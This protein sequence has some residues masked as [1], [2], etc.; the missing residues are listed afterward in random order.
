MRAYSLSSNLMHLISF[1]CLIGVGRAS[2][3]ILNIIVRLGILNLSV[4]LDF[5][6]KAF[7]FFL[8]FF[9]FIFKLYIIVYRTVLWTL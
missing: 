8:L 4:A 9:Y 5:R 2:N 3:T 6:G 7:F 1:S